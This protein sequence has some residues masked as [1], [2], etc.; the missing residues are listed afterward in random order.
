MA[1]GDSNDFRR[2]TGGTP[3]ILDNEISDSIR[4]MLRDDADKTLPDEMESTA[5]STDNDGLV[6]MFVLILSSLIGIVGLVIMIV[7]LAGGLVLFLLGAAGFGGCIYQTQIDDREMKKASAIDESRRAHLQSLQQTRLQQR[8]QALNSLTTLESSRMNNYAQIEVAKINAG[9]TVE[10]SKYQALG[11][12]ANLDHEKQ[13][14]RLQRK[15]EAREA[16][17]ERQWKSDE[18]AEDRTHDMEKLLERL[19]HELEMWKERIQ[20]EYRGEPERMQEELDAW[21]LERM[22][23]EAIDQEMDEDKKLRYIKAFEKR[24]HRRNA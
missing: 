12:G 24:M 18:A 5:W 8:G 15:L 9:A 22:A 7:N 23:R 10:A 2:H 1:S 16:R 19:D 4:D 20:V 21:E 17:L 6:W 3:L 13:L 14:L 11:T